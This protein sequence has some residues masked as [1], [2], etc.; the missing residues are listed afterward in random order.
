MVSRRAEAIAMPSSAICLSTASSQAAS[1]RASSR[2]RLRERNA[3]SKAAAR[4][5]CPGSIAST[6]RSTKRL[7]SP[8][9]PLNSPSSEGVIHTR[10]RCSLKTLDEAAGAP[11]RR[12][13]RIG[14][15]E[16]CSRSIPVPSTAGPSGPSRSATIANRPDPPMRAISASGA[17]RRPRPGARSD[18]AS[19]RF[20]LPTP[21]SPQSAISIGSNSA[22]SSGKLRKSVSLRRVTARRGHASSTCPPC[23]AARLLT[24]ASASARR[25]W[26]PPRAPASAWEN[27]VRRA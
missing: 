26:M 13:L 3:C 14:F 15:D 19:S 6:S 27:R 25:A 2:S 24:R 8:G 17:R 16:P 10:R 5:A 1:G 9:G 18:K 12:V 21:F 11:L 7:R 23:E 22:S 4:D 20:V